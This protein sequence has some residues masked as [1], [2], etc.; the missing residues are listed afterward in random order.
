MKGKNI[1][2]SQY[3][4]ENC[5]TYK[6]AWK[7]FQDGMIENAFKD[8]LGNIIV[9]VIDDVDYSLCVTYAIVSTT[10]QK[11]DSNRQENR[12]INY[13]NQNNLK[14][15]KKYKEVGSWMNDNRAKLIELL[16]D[17][18][19]NTSITENK[20]RLNRFGFNYIETLL[21]K[22]GK[23]VIVVNQNEDIKEDLINDLV[24][25]IYSFS[26]RMYGLRRKKNKEEV[27]EFL[28]KNNIYL[29]HD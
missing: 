24:S 20:D 3:A 28:R 22:M 16:N 5:I 19:W 29:H 27:L 26:A 6:T 17:D 11:D 23:K 13:V 15:V 10:K 1:K 8:S 14:L 18:S 25:I 12:L 2:L 21:N 4:K 9:K 7:R